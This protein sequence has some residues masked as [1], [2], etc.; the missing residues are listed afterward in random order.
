MKVKE[1]EQIKEKIENLYKNLLLELN[2]DE[3][4]TNIKYCKEA[5]I[6]PQMEDNIGI[7]EDI[8]IVEK[9]SITENGESQKSYEIYLEEGQRV[10]YISKEGEIVFDKEYIE[11]LKERYKGLFEKIKIEDVKV[12][13]D[14]VLEEDE[15][16]VEMTQE[17]IEEDE[18]KQDKEE[19]QEQ[20]E[21]QDENDKEVEK[22]AK[23]TGISEKEM[24]ACTKLNPNEKITDTENFYDI[25]PSTKQ[26]EKIYVVASNKNTKGNSMFYF[27][28][29]TKD[30]MA[31]QIE[32]LEPTE[33][34][35]TTKEVIS[36]NRDGSEIKEKQVS[37]LFKVGDYNKGFSVS[38]G[39]YGVIEAEYVRRTQDNKYI[40]SNIN[41]TT[42]KPSTKEVK[43]FMSD[44]RNPYLQNNADR[45][46]KQIEEKQ[47]EETNIKNIDDDE[48]ND[49]IIDVDEEIKL[50]NGDVTTLRKEA[51]K[52]GIDI[53]EYVT[54]CEEVPA[55]TIQEK[56]EEVNEQIEE[57]IV[58]EVV[59]EL[60]DER[61]P[62]G[63]AY[64]RM[65]RG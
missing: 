36:I 62:W 24:K 25:V 44:T 49:T 30:G 16:I 17:E 65:N 23:A 29:I 20:E 6:V 12:D 35:N 22:I 51:E 52:F 13:I 42:Q 2:E 39:D 21:K 4:I 14:K 15:E 57:E 53:E 56:I 1:K 40:S 64:R 54:R 26:Y 8:Y 18:K 28:G 7:E 60:E 46:E 47:N 48:Y 38:I 34:T 5:K 32:D 31:E 10:A 58:D 27:V 3:K 45:A 37:A 61:T 63:D 9:E 43:E 41:T 50:D 55:E 11:L 19:T 59:E 33:G